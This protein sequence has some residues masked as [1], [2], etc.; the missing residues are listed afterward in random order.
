MKNLTLLIKPAS[1][2]CNMRCKYCF[3]ADVSNARTVKSYGLMSESMLELIVRKALEEATETCQ[4]GFQG[5]EPTLA[6]LGFYK[7][8]IEF[9][10]IFNKNGVTISH[11]FQTNGLLIDDE[12]ASFFAENHFLVGL[13][14]DATKSIHD[15]M[16]VDSADKGTHGRCLKAA[17]L[18]EK[19]D[20][21]F[22]ILSVVTH[23]FASDPEKV[24]RFY[25]DKDYRYIQF[26]PCLDSFNEECG[27]ASYSLNA[28]DYGKFLCAIFDLWY[29]DLNQRN[30]YSIRMFNNYINILA[31]FAPENCAMNGMCT[32]Y[33]LIES[34]GNVYPCDFYAVDEFLLGN[35]ASA[36]FEEMLNGEKAKEFVDMSRKVDPKCRMCVY[37]YLCR[38]GCRRDRNKVIGKELGLNRYCEAYKKLFDHS[39]PRMKKITQR[40]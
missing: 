27:Q 13:S 11:T 25:K 12:W 1:S 9:E 19:H 30:Y 36:S 33:A 16:R 40:G 37:Y 15:A 28:E 3:Y 29:E 39:L 20:V 8:L 32:A 14:I 18:L 10:K 38:G 2:L 35:V 22:N 7:K 24:Y 26:I 34:N 4:I 6:G 5:G 31:G 21:D 23:K 17:R